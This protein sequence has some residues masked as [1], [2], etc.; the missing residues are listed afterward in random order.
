MGGGDQGD[1][2][3]TQSGECI[4]DLLQ[5]QVLIVAE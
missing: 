3:A 2:P 1:I 5:V 4:I